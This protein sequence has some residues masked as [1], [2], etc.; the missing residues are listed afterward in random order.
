[1][2]SHGT[3]SEV[4]RH[5][6]GNPAMRVVA[7]DLPK[8]GA[9]ARRDRGGEESLLGLSVPRERVF[10]AFVWN[11]PV[12]DRVDQSLEDRGL[13]FRVPGTLG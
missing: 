4:T 13:D 12:L 1:M 8:R 3:H 10:G 5:L 6:V 11:A 7:Q 9:A 2:K